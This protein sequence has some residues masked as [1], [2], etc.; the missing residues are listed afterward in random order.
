M[1]SLQHLQVLNINIKLCN[2]IGLVHFYGPE[3]AALMQLRFNQQMKCSA[4]TKQAASMGQDVCVVGPH[5]G[6]DHSVGLCCGGTQ[7]E[8]ELLAHRNSVS[9][10]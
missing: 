10:Q 4:Y 5:V 9:Y 7:D 3:R 1:Y 2:C 8:L 6:D